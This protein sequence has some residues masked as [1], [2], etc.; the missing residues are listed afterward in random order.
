MKT[1]S[2]HPMGLARHPA[3]DKAGCV[4]VQRDCFIVNR[5]ASPLPLLL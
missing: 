4:I 3:G 1:L 2:E 5:L